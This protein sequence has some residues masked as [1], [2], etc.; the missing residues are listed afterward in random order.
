[1]AQIYEQ[2]DYKELSYKNHKQLLSSLPK[3]LRFND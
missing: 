3:P 2:L 1:M